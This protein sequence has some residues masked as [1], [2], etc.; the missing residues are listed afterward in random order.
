[1]RTAL[2]RRGA[3]M[4]GTCSITFDRKRALA[5]GG[6]PEQFR[7]QYEDQALIAKLM[8]AAV[9]VVLEEPLVKYRQHAA[10]LTHRL[11]RSGEYRS[12]RPHAALF[13]YLQWLRRYVTEQTPQFPELDRILERRLWPTRH[14]RLSSAYESVRSVYRMLRGTRTA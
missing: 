12:G 9:T 1:L 6:I 14:P 4:P 8:L 13:E 3:A 11:G 5:L 7:S 10:S 2:G